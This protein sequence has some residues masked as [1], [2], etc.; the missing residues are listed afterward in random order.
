MEGWKVCDKVGEN[1]WDSRHKF[2]V[3]KT[4]ATDSYYAKARTQAEQPVNRDLVLEIKLILFEGA[5]VPHIHDYHEDKSKG[6]RDPSSFKK[7][8]ERS[9]EVQGFNCPK[10][11]YEAYCKKHAPVPAQHDN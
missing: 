11:D 9:R 8:N 5:E 1:C 4:N 6:N 7:L 2:S 3:N 10:E